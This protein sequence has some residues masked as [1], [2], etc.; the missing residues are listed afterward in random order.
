MLIVWELALAGC[1][2]SARTDSAPQQEPKSSASTTAIATSPSTTEEAEPKRS[3]STSLWDRLP[4]APSTRTPD[5]T[6]LDEPASTLNPAL[7]DTSE[8]DS[9]VDELPPPASERLATPVGE[10]DGVEEGDAAANLQA[11]PLRSA[12]G[13]PAPKRAPGYLPGSAN[14]LREPTEDRVAGPYYRS[15]RRAAMAKAD[16][17]Q[18]EESRG[19]PN[20]LELSGSEAPPAPEGSPVPWEPVETN[21]DADPPLSD[22]A[23]AL[24]P[25]VDDYGASSR[26]SRDAD[27]LEMVAPS[28]AS[29]EKV[30]RVFYATDRKARYDSTAKSFIPTVLGSVLLLA[31]LV[32]TVALSRRSLRLAAA[33][34]FAGLIGLVILTIGICRSRHGPPPANDRKLAFGSERGTIQYGYCDVSIPPVHESG[35]VERPS[36]LRLEFAEREDRHF[37]IKTVE[38]LPLNDFFATM[39]SKVA[40]SPQRDLFVFVHGYNVTFDIAARRT[41]QMTNDLGFQGAPVFFSWPSQGEFS[42]YTVDEAA[43]SWAAPHLRQFLVELVEKSN[44]QRVHLIG[45]SMGNRALV[46]AIRSLRLEFPDRQRLF[47]EIVLAA[48]DIDA[49]EFKNEIAPAIVTAAERVTL[50]ASSNDRALMASRLI[51]GYSRAGESGDNLVVIPGIETVDVSQ[52]D[53]SFLGHSY[54]GSSGPV[55]RDL[56]AIFRG[57]SPVRSRPWLQIDEQHQTK[58]W[59]LAAEKSIATRPRP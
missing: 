38:S 2:S 37:V 53:H 47:N 17:T 43:V 58:F 20:D 11:N 21:T 6:G 51:H 32:G 34:G 15:P 42:D 10:R 14:P 39:R 46:D 36:I 1:G 27:G 31:S 3:D 41:A 33:C 29:G 40:H 50:Y 18:P 9:V 13:P 25:A 56:Q 24:R 59:R 16:G 57:E 44:A 52:M 55:L 26:R 30:V 19:I 49:E 8:S 12:W 4:I 35:Q 45:H 54:Y 22:P 23:T 5:W 28:T 48:P 7:P